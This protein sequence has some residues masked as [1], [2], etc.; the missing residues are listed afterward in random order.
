MDL[1]SLSGVC[2]RND[3]GKWRLQEG[4][5]F[6]D[7]LPLEC[8]DHTES[9]PLAGGARVIYNHT[10]KRWHVLPPP[11]PTPSVDELRSEVDSTERSQSFDDKDGRYG[12]YYKCVSIYRRCAFFTELNFREILSDARRSHTT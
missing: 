4:C 9:F 3:R 12:V 6:H 8:E 1:I 11:T 2:L 10:H 5:N 7:P